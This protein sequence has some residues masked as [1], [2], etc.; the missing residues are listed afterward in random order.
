MNLYEVNDD[1]LSSEAQKKPPAE[2]A[3][4]PLPVFLH[5]LT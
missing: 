3:G 5:Y 4:K 2:N 1:G